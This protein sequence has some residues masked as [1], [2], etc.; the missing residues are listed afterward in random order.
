MNDIISLLQNTLKLSPE[1]YFIKDY[2]V[3]IVHEKGRVNEK[4]ILEYLNS[5][6]FFDPNGL[7]AHS[8]D[9]KT[10][11]LLQKDASNYIKSVSYAISKKKIYE[12][13]IFAEK[14]PHDRWKK[15]VDDDA[16]EA[17]IEISHFT[18]EIEPKKIETELRNIMRSRKEVPLLKKVG[19]IWI[20]YCDKTQDV[21]NIMQHY[22]LENVK[23]VS[24]E[25][26]TIFIGYNGEL[27][28]INM[29]YFVYP[30]K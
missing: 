28:N 29:R 24:T 8:Y 15:I 13:Y 25:E 27:Q 23:S 14:F 9:D 11:T 6:N 4:Q 1:L 21:S 17:V 16:L 5:L 20:A 19:F 18:N 26:Q 3:K 2:P 22:F 7:S 30:P 12:N 10:I